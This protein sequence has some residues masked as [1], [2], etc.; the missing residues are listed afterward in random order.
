MGVLDIAML[1]MLGVLNQTFNSAQEQLKE[2][3][4]FCFVGKRKG[5]EIEEG[6][7]ETLMLT[8]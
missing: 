2:I 6:G 5:N 7:M 1:D 8:G 4:T 3:I